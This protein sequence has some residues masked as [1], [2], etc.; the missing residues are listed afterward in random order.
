MQSGNNSTRQ[1]LLTIGGI[2]ILLRSQHSPFWPFADRRYSNFYSTEQIRPEETVDLQVVNQSRGTQNDPQQTAISDRDGVVRMVRGHGIGRWNKQQHAA[3]IEQPHDTFLPP[4]RYPESICDSLLRIIVSYRVME[5]G[6][7]LIHGAGLIRDGRGYLFIGQSGAGKS[8]VARC[9]AHST[10]VLSDD[11]TVAYLTDAGGRIYGTPFFG[12]Y[13]TAGANLGAPLAGIYFLHQAPE[14]KTV[15]LAPHVALPKLLRSTMF[16]GTD[17]SSAKGVLDL[18][19]A[20]CSQI[21][22]HTLHFLP[23]NSFWRCIRV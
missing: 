5:R 9:S 2:P 1:K 18:A 16:Y 4:A 15:S 6:G 14:N 11:L 10:T 7:L 23:E 3:R 21:S 19:L 17:R 20:F 22:C 13:A 12:E 8:T